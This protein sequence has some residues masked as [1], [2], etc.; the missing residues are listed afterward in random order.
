MRGPIAFDG[1]FKSGEGVFFQNSGIKSLTQDQDPVIMV[2]GHYYS[3]WPSMILSDTERYRG[4]T[5]FMECSF[6]TSKVLHPN[7]PGNS[8]PTGQWHLG[9]F[10]INDVPRSTPVKRD[11]RLCRI[12]R[13]VLLIQGIS[14]AL[15]RLLGVENIPRVD[16]G[17]PLAGL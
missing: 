6:Y 17:R 7:I 4:I 12:E 3:S 16:A 8:V 14:E 13:V 5:K 9:A 11:P 15:D 1:F 2:N 10:G